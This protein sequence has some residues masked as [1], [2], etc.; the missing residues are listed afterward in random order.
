M[1]FVEQLALRILPYILGLRAAGYDARPLLSYVELFAGESAI[2]RGLSA[3]GYNGHRFDARYSESHNFLTP[4]GYLAAVAAIMRIHVNGVVWFGPP[5]STWVWMSRHSTKR[6]E[7]LHR[8]YLGFWSSRDSAT[9]F[10]L[11]PGAAAPHIQTSSRKAEALGLRP[12]T[13]GPNWEV[14]RFRPGVRTESDPD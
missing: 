11:P 9:G 4:V 12:V 14:F 8:C 2:S 10:L 7:D 13:P 3:F 6:N 1:T 5:C